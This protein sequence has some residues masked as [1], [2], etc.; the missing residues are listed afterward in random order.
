MN[1]TTA[2][3]IFI[4]ALTMVFIS[5]SV[6][7]EASEVNN[8]IRRLD[9]SAFPKLPKNI[10]RSLEFRSCT[11]P[12][13]FEELRPHNVIRGEFIKKG[14]KDWAV[15]CSKDGISTILIFKADSAKNVSEIESSSDEKWTQSYGDGEYGFS[16]QIIVA[17][18]KQIMQY[19]K[20][21]KELTGEEQDLPLITHDGIDDIFVSKASVVHYY[22]KGQWLELSG[23][24]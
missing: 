6:Y 15:L 19:N 8:T 7:A 12:Q 4:F 14:Q 24:D 13:V 23:S 3:K 20:N 1:K 11:I 21:L 18:K 9:P 10:R 17:G 5:I 22:Y 2:Y 16:R